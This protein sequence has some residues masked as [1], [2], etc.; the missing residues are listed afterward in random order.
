MSLFSNLRS[1]AG[2]K[3]LE[4]IVTTLCWMG[5]NAVWSEAMIAEQLGRDDP[6]LASDLARAEQ[7]GIVRRE[8][9]GLC[10]T[11][12]G[13]QLAADSDASPLDVRADKEASG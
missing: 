11:D 10:L 12:R 2:D 1:V 4:Y 5:G 8:A 9:T 13:W 7:R 3:D 6:C